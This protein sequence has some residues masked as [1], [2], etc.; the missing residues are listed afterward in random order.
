[1]TLSRNSSGLPPC[2]ISTSCCSHSRA[3]SPWMPTSVAAFLVLP[4]RR[5]AGFGDAVH[6]GGADLHLDRRAVRPEQRGVQR[7]VAVHARD[8]DVVLE[9]AGHRLEHRVHDAERAVTRVGLVDDEAEAVHVDDLVQRDLL[10]PHLLVDAVDVLL[11]PFDRCGNLRVVE[12]FLERRGDAADELLVVAARGLHGRLDHLVALRV[13]RAEAEVL[14]LALDRVH[15]ETVRDRRV[16]LERL[17]R[18]RAALRRRHRAERAHVVGAVR[19]LDHDHADVAD[20]RQQHLAE[21][22]GLRLGAAAELDLV[23]LA[24]AVDEF[25]HVATEARGDLVLGVRRVLHDV[26]E[27]RGHHR[28]RVELEVGEQVGDGDRVR[29]VRLARTAPLAVMGL[30]REVVRFLDQFDLVGRQVG[31]QLRNELVDADGASSVGQQA[32][33]GRRDVHGRA[34]SGG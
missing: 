16:D 34:R 18:D 30:E 31:L 14:E 22:L 33:Q 28:L 25:R 1:M 27:D 8:R 23:E 7:L 11:A 21:A 10:A 15:A 6:L 12:R 3:R 4:V 17:A 13:Q 2:W 24:D 5:D 19:E 29:D 20:H 9:A 32:A 26:V